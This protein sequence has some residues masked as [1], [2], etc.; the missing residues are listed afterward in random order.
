MV[1]MPIMKL[2]LVSV[3]IFIDTKDAGKLRVW[4][5]KREE[6][7]PLSG[8]WEFPG[9]KIE[10]GE[11]SRD[12]LIRE[13]KEEVGID[14]SDDPIKPFK[15][16]KYEYGD[17]RVVLHTFLVKRVNLPE[18]GRW[19]EM[20]QEEDLANFENEIP[21]AN[22]EMFLELFRYL[23]EIKDLENREQIWM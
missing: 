8:L 4:A 20:S 1:E 12:C 18:S 15:V 23:N 5:Q 14:I 22:K 10:D 19:L 7:G 21:A 16:Y 3:G 11:E 6:E 2:V 17:R 13:I 9:G